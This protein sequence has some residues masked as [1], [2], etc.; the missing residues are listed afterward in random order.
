MKE[1]NL[2]TWHRR[3]GIILVLFVILQA[4]SGFLIALGD[5]M[6]SMNPHTEHAVT[7]TTVDEEE[8]FWDEALE[9]IHFGA[10]TA[11]GGYR[12]LLGAGILWMAV[13]G[14][15]IFFRIRARAHKR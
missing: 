9:F 7:A 5:F 12:I 2:R 4:G 15:L 1:V 14:G 13:S 3:I 6:L 8:E 11:G 10:G